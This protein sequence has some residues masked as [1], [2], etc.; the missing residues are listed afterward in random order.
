MNKNFSQY[1]VK[2]TKNEVKDLDLSKREVAIYLSTFDVIDSDNDMIAKGA[3]E[4]SLKERFINNESNRK[5][6][7]LR[8]HDWQHQIGKFTRLEE[9][10][11]GLFA[12]GELGTS[13]KGEDALRD[14]DEGIITEHSIG[15]QYIEDRVKWIEDTSVKDDGYYLIEEVKLYEGSAVTFGANPYTEVIATGKAEDKID[16]FKKLSREINVVTKALINGRGTDER[17][18]NLEMKLK[19]LNARIIDLAMIEPVTRSKTGEVKQIDNIPSFSWSKMY[20]LIEVK[21]PFADYPEQA[22]KNAKK[23]IELN[24]ANGNDCATNVGKQRARDIVA[25][26]GFSL[27]VLKRTYSYL[28]RAKE[29]YNPNDETACGTI[30]YLLWGGDAMRSW[31]E[32]KLSELEN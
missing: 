11:K 6:A 7:Y 5:I 30:S 13:T 26:R 32:K 17:L 4:K 14:Y 15:F 16:L 24:E 20:N 21:E 12:V 25:K 19:Y 22:I 10:N 9:D 31:A 8:Y 3:F 1:S 28:T 18:Y 23:G 27:D 2:Q 29:Y